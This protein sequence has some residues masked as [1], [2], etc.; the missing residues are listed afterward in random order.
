[1]MLK[2]LLLLAVAVTTMGA[3]AAPLTPQEALNRLSHNSTKAAG[4]KSF[5]VSDLVYTE[6]RGN[7]PMLY[8]F[9]KADAGF[10][11]LSA[12]DNAFPILGYSDEGSFDPQNIPEN[13][14]WWLGEYADQIASAANADD[15]SATRYAVPKTDND[16]EVIYP[17]CGYTRWDQSSPFNSMCPEVDGTLCYTGC[18][19]TAMAQLMK[20]HNWPVTGVGSNSYTWND[21]TLSADFS[22]MTFD[23]D[24]M[25]PH[26]TGS[27]TDAQNEAV[28]LLMK[29]CGY[30]VD[31][32]Y[33][34]SASGAQ[35]H[36]VAPALVNF[37]N[38]GYET[39]SVV[40]S[41][42]GYSDWVDIIYDSL[43]KGDAVFYAGSNSSSGHAF[44][45]DGYD[46]N[47]YFHLNWG[48]GG[49]SNGYFLLN[50]LDPSNQ[51]IGGSTSGYDQGQS[52]II[53]AA[54]K[55]EDSTP[56]YM[57][58]LYSDFSATYD[59]DSRALTFN[60][61]FENTS[62]LTVNYRLGVE[63]TDTQGNVSYLMSPYTFSIKPY[64]YYSSYSVTLPDD[65][66]VG[67]YTIKAVYAPVS[68]AQTNSDSSSDSAPRRMD[69]ATLNWQ[70]VKA[71][72]EKECI[73]TLDIAE[74]GTVTVLE[75]DA[76]QLLSA[77]NLSPNSTLMLGKSFNVSAD[78]T[79]PNDVDQTVTFYFGL[80]STDGN[81]NLLNYTAPYTTDIRAGETK[82][83]NVDTKF[84][85]DSSTPAGEYYLALFQLNSEGYLHVISNSL[86]TVQYLEAAT[87]SITGSNLVIHDNGAVDSSQIQCT[88]T[89]SCSEGAYA[90]PLTCFLFDGNYRTYLKESCRT[91]NVYIAEGETKDVDFTCSFTDVE[92]NTTYTLHVQ[93]GS[94]YLTRATFTVVTTDVPTLLAADSRN[95]IT[96]VSDNTWS[97]NAP[98]DITAVAIYGMDGTRHNAAVAISGTTATIDATALL[99]GIYAV[100]VTTT[101][102]VT[103]SKMKR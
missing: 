72:P 102:G 54:P 76:L 59:A 3:L 95:A 23:W 91:R 25:A 55:T 2:R 57:L 31:M 20:S 85:N 50:A 71:S 74:D 61:G 82:T 77:A 60:G 6:S 27:E 58:G 87:T 70:E 101:E 78:I 67:D 42:F 100:T 24:N 89:L 30:S 38:Y 4:S 40:R 81:Y 9:S 53:Y 29:A 62:A 97:V 80:L 56:T 47:D 93:A 68:Y 45:V 103:V 11:L 34:T 16:K 14:R 33:G 13:M 8:L 5:T 19:A 86:V 99:P 12:D 75:K 98:A 79:S 43:K 48:W 39:A 36:K 44:V 92:P 7:L 10:L 22:T 51:G 1:M 37:F 46:T 35:S 17:L 65:M 73:A 64:Y 96:E 28:A 63:F 18:V 52:A 83:I 66:A 94:D 84:T 26:Y 90:A 88:I 49:S 69:T 21:Q 41:N 15:A 32:S